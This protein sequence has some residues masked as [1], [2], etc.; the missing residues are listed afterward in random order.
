MT[1]LR[2]PNNRRVVMQYEFAVI[3]AQRRTKALGTTHYVYQDYGDVLNEEYTY[4]VVAK[5]SQTE[6]D[7]AL[8]YTVFPDGSEIRR[9]E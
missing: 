3:E 7:N 6:F 1:L 5:Q 2:R 8:V 4:F 9:P